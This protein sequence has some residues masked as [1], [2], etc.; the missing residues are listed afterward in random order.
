MSTTVRNTKEYLDPDKFRF[1][2]LI[3]GLAGTGKTSWLGSCKPEDIG[4]AACETGIGNGLL[5][6]AANGFDHI[7][8]ENLADLES[9][10]K[11]NVFKNKKIL[12]LDSL[13]AVARTLIKDAALRIPR[14][15]GETDKRKAGVPE[16]DDFGVIAGFTQKYLNMLLTCN[17]TCHVLVTATEKFD[18]VNENDPP[19]TESTFGPNL[20]GQ[21]YTEAP[22]LFDFV[23]RMRVRPVLANPA[24]AKSRYN[25]RYF[26]TDKDSNTLA[27]CR[28]NDGRGVALLDKEEIFDLK[29][30][31]GSFY[32]LVE[33]I[34]GKYR[35]IQAKQAGTK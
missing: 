13:S 32:Y 26:I 35:E 5:S 8:L 23:L 21:M 20:A 1:I 17:P 10:C 14:A 3:Y 28:S 11:G 27:K 24:D 33:K 34:V 2:G 18:K 25:Q 9:F 19:G 30:G 4:I 29:T 16:L 31:Q 22:A 6:I 12:A 7:I 15:R